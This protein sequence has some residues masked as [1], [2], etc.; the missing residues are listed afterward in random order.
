MAT[1]FYDKGWRI[2]YIYCVLFCTSFK[3][4]CLVLYRFHEQPYSSNSIQECNNKNTNRDHSTTSSEKG[5]KKERLVLTTPTYSLRSFPWT[6]CG[7]VK[8]EPKQPISK[9]KRKKPSNQQRN[10]QDLIQV[11][12]CIGSLTLELGQIFP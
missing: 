12:L 11:E 1:H 6:C 5:T 8:L 3:I 9:L 4:M 10:A 7:L 2:L